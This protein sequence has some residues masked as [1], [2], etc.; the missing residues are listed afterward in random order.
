MDDATTT[1]QLDRFARALVVTAHPD[2]VDFGAAGTVAMLVDAGCDVAYCIVT[3][4]QAGGSDRGVDR[5][6]IPAIRRAEQR[7]AAA[8]VGV[9]DV[10]FLGHVDGEV[11]ADLD[12]ARD[13]SREIRTHRPD[14]VITFSPERNYARVGVSHPDH[15]A[16]G[17]ATLDAVYPFARNPFAFP[18]LLEHE[19]LEPHIVGEVWLQ[20]DEQS[21]LCV[22]ITDVIDRK[23]A[24]IAAHV[25]Q[26]ADPTALG[27]RVRGWLAD[28]ARRGGLPEGRLAESFRVV[29]IS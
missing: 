19:G 18:T 10:T 28:G 27:E 3:D 17:S 29:R 2:D 23:L 14:L 5:A 20:G 24:A 6:E 12:L 16:V 4:G 9:T 13:I 7:A 25:S 11:V 21:D 26:V 22:D 1:V 8:E 15:R